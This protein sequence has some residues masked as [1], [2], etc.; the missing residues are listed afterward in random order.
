MT[1]PLQ[2]LPDHNGT[3][4]YRE[5]HLAVQQLLRNSGNTGIGYAVPKTKPQLK[6]KLLENV[7]ANS[8]LHITANG[9]ARLATATNASL[10]CNGFSSAAGSAGSFILANLSGSVIQNQDSWLGL[11]VGVTSPIGALNPPA[12]IV[13][14]LGVKIT[15]STL[16]FQFTPP[17]LL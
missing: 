13:Q 6:V 10:F 2:H 3:T 12:K 1:Q 5:L 17:T 14:W 8:A 9:E 15:P 16:L 4:E 11:P 7:A